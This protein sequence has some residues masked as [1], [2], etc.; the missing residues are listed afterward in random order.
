MFFDFLLYNNL[1]LDKF[2][3]ILLTLLL[4]LQITILLLVLNI[5]KANFLNNLIVFNIELNHVAI[6]LNLKS[7]ISR[8]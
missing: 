4:L 5:F 6:L 3:T 8:N 7:N 2:L 1:N